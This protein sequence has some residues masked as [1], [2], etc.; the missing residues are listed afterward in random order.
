MAG[1]DA[2][3]VAAMRKALV[4][5][6]HDF[7]SFR[8]DVEHGNLHMLQ[9][10]DFVKGFIPLMES[11]IAA[12]PRNCDVYDVED[13]AA[14]CMQAIDAAWHEIDTIRA[15][16]GWMLATAKGKGTSSE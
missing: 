10:M 11:A 8:E 1:N 5:F 15:T 12:P 14:E 6:V 16:I 2:G 4:F 9:C 7:A 13:G 3:N